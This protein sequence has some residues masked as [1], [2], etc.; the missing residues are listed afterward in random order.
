M[1]ELRI[2][3]TV[4]KYYGTAQYHSKASE[5]NIFIGMHVN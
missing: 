2:V 1:R 5:V 3:T 4:I